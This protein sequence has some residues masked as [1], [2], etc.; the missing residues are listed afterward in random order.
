MPTPRQTIRPSHQVVRSISYPHNDH[1]V[2]FTSR[3][4]RPRRKSHSWTALAVVL[5]I[6]LG[7]FAFMKLHRSNGEVMASNS[8][9]SPAAEQQ[10]VPTKIDF[11]TMGNTIQSVIQQYPGMDI[12]VAVI[13]IKTNEAQAY[14]VGDPFV[15]ASTAK[16]LTALAYL[17]D[18]EQGTAS[19]DQQVGSMNAQSAMEA[20][21]VD[22]DNAAWKNFNNTVMSHTELAQYATSIGLNNYDP[23]ANTTTPS[24][25]A[26]LLS[27]LY[28]EKLVNQEHTQLLLSYMA[29]AK[30][31]EFIINS[32]P[33][34]TKVYHKPGYLVD[35]MHDAAIID[36]GTRPYV[37]VIFTKSRTAN[38]YN[39]ANGEQVF[40]QITKATTAAFGQ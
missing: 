10:P 35:R 38:T 24:N 5:V 11:A 8:S 21:I 18:V 22:S 23:D 2:P 36:N 25:I 30:E 1:A 13:D 27:N 19:L 32:V 14:G 26:V 29:R 12:G 7:G 15:A 6:V 34:G 37:L 40:T 31:V 20:M 28:Q 3:R 33:A 9:E 17:H 16:L 4:T 39:Y